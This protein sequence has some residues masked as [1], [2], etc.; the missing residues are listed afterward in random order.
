VERAGNLL[1]VGRYWDWFQL[2]WS[3]GSFKHDFV[4]QVTAGANL[5]RVSRDWTERS[6]SHLQMRGA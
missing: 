5:Q 2:Q 1:A 6:G 3:D 4:H